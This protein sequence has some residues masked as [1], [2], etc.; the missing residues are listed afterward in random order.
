MEVWAKSPHAAKFGSIWEV[1][2]RKSDVCEGLPGPAFGRKTKQDEFMQQSFHWFWLSDSGSLYVPHMCV[3]GHALHLCALCLS[4]QRITFVLVWRQTW[5]M[6]LK[7][8]LHYW[9]CVLYRNALN[10][11]LPLQMRDRWG[12]MVKK[13]EI[14]QTR[15]RSYSGILDNN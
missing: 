6:S 4:H 12:P 10:W 14:T 11:L 7:W 13:K 15:I 8:N 5:G 2:F 3:R 9:P 1:R